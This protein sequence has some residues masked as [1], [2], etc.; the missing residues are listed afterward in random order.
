[1]S[2]TKTKVVDIQFSFNNKELLELL[3]GRAQALKQVNS[4]QLEDYELLLDDVKAEQFEQIRTPNTFFC[5]FEEALASQTLLKLDRR[6]K[7]GMHHIK[8][9]R[10]SHPSDIMWENRGLSSGKRCCR[11]VCFLGILMPILV[12]YF[13]YLIDVTLSWKIILTS[14]WITPDCTNVHVRFPEGSL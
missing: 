3:S 13:Q 14:R 6:L 8:L 12:F 11:I 10:A 4:Q 2:H 7:L 9:T 1:M 5:T